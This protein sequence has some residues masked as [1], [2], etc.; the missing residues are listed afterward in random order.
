MQAKDN[1]SNSQH[2]DVSPESWLS[3]Y[4]D[5]LYRYAMLHVGNPAQAED[6]VQETLVA[7]LEGLDR[8]AGR[9]SEK[10]WLTGILRHKILDY[11]RR[12]GREMASG[13]GDIEALAD[14]A[15]TDI[16]T[17]FDERG[18]W[19]TP[20]QD[21]GLPEQRETDQQFLQ[22]LAR[23]MRGLKPAMATAFVLKELDGHSNQQISKELGVSDS[24]CGVLLYRARMSLRR[25][26]DLRW[27]DD[28][29]AN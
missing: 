11:L 22:V 8:F 1:I 25:C 4:G 18:H 9:A 14:S 13:D 3:D 10:T 29:S 28:E 15:A 27:V 6:L 24:N 17:M 21:W 23:C 26:L 19:M 20:P 2:R 5:Q 12:S 7:G 16:G